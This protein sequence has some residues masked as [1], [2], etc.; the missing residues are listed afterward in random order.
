M[1]KNAE[2]KRFS[3]ASGITANILGHGGQLMLVENTFSKGAIA[4]SHQHPHE[5]VCYIVEGSFEFTLE[6]QKY[7][8]EKG[9]SL[10]IPSDSIHSGVALEDSIIL[11]IF[12]PQRDD[13]LEK[14]K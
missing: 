3:L 7:I 8:L 11:D 6:T 2:G 12:T 9:D 5:Q 13:F 14:V 4:P 10:Y 1:V